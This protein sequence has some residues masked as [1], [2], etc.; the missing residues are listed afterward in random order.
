MTIK[1]S[2]EDTALIRQAS[3]F[4]DLSEGA[5]TTLL[6]EAAVKS[7]GRNETLFMQGDPASAFFIILEG[8][9]KIYRLTH[10]GGEAVVGV[11]TRGQSFAEA[12][13]F[14]SGVYPASAES[15]TDT[16]ILIIPTRRLP[17]VIRSAPEI[18]LKMLASL[19]QHLHGLVHQVQQLKAHT[20]AQRLAEFLLSLAPVDTGACTIVLPYD[21]ALIA[22]HLGM[23]PESLSRAFLR[24]REYGVRVKQ[25]MATISDVEILRDF[26]EQERAEI[27]RS[28]G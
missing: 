12:V 17:D 27:L 11:F 26:F 20:G 28:R 10:S 4:K 19:S 18:G 3:L 9:V 23:K 2:P 6:A 16:R 1:F 25:N 15:V 13:A 21:K 22:G 5:L 7:M 8:W 14:T 24:L